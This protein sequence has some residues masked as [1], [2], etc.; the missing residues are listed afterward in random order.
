MRKTPLTP[1]SPALAVASTPPPASCYHL[2][3]G[4]VIFLR[5]G[6]D[7]LEELNLNTTIVTD[8]GKVTA[9]HIGKAQ[10][11]LQLLLFQRGDAE[12]NVVDV[13]IMAISKLGWMTQAEFVAGVES[14]QNAA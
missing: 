14:L 9:N 6:S 11:S 4:K 3:A 5:K 7:V 10:Q 8:D 13:F 2:V 1:M 12:L